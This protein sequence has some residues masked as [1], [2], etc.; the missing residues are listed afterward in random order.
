MRGG[1]RGGG[2]GARGFLFK[3]LYEEIIFKKLYFFQAFLSLPP[4]APSPS[5]GTQQHLEKP[6][7]ELSAFE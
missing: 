4:L 1:G 5:P 3:E 6:I 2:K 7:S